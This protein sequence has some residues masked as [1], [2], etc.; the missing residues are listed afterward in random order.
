MTESIYNNSET[1]V[2][3]KQQLFHN[4]SQSLAIKNLKIGR[5]E[6]KSW[7]GLRQALIYLLKKKCVW[8]EEELVSAVPIIFALHPAIW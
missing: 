2:I 1:P 6:Q 7:I 3:L 8:E 4:Y 5:L